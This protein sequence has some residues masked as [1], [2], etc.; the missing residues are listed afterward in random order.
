MKKWGYKRCEDIV[1]VKTNKK[2]H[3]N[4][5]PYIAENSILHRCKEHCLVGLK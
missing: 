3:G 5:R 4:E 1:W 2:K